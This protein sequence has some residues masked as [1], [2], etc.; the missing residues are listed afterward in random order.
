MVAPNLL[1]GGRRHGFLK[2]VVT[3]PELRWRGHGRAVV[4]A[5]L[6]RAWADACHHVLMRS[7]R[8]NS[9]VAYVA[10]GSRRSGEA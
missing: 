5:A 10:Q 3:H 1:R 8:P 2:N 9:R 7:K 6:S 4:A